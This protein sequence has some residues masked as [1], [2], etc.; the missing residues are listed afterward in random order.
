MTPA[1]YLLSNWQS[2]APML[3]VQGTWKTLPFGLLLVRVPQLPYLN[4][5]E[6]TK[7]ITNLEG[8][9][10]KREEHQIDLIK[11]II[12]NLTTRKIINTLKEI[13]V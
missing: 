11:E 1:S 13:G 6:L 12:N 2:P 7:K 3:L 10:S 9:S 4:T 8:P 5:S